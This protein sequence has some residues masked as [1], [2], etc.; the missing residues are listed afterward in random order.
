MPCR[1]PEEF[2]GQAINGLFGTI[3]A[4]TAS[5]IGGEMQLERFAVRLIGRS[6]ELV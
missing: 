1:A 4:R 6:S 2:S 5:L 3:D